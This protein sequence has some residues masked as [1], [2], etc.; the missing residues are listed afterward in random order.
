MQGYD[1]IPPG[2]YDWS[3][4]KDPT[5]HFFHR[6]SDIAAVDISCIKLPKE[7]T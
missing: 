7:Q 6:V 5:H 3:R 2:I 4:W 1:K